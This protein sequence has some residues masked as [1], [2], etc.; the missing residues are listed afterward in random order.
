MSELRWKAI[1]VAQSRTIPE[2]E[3]PTGKVSE[4][5]SSNTFTDEVMK[6]LLTAE[7]YEK[8]SQAIRTGE[9]IEGKVA[10]EVAAAMK[11]WATSKGATHYTHWFQPLTGGTAEKHD[12]FLMC[13]A[14]VMRL[15]N[16]K[17]RHWFSRS[18]MLPP[19]PAVA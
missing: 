1:Q 6:E 10:D 15:K 4:Y 11:T 5:Y 2:V 8:V 9:N 12:S 14:M 13:R 7:S 17:V 3:I 18:P 19:F 16:S